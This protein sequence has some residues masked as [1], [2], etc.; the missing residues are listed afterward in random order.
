MQSGNPHAHPDERCTRAGNREIGNLRR[1]A[2]MP[3]FVL[4]VD[5]GGMLGFAAECQA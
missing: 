1:H 4:A 3:F 5:A 2:T